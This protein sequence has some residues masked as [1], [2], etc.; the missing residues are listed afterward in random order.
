MFLL[1]LLYATLCIGFNVYFMVTAG[2]SPK[3][4]ITTVLIM[5]V[6]LIKDLKSKIIIDGEM[7]Y[8]EKLFKKRSFPIHDIAQVIKGRKTAY[9][10]YTIDYYVIDENFKE[11]FVFPESLPQKKEVEH[12]SKT[13]NRINPKARVNLFKT[14]FR[15]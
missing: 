1:Y 9:Q 5:S 10:S 2:L 7:M 4:L 6:M 8:Y 14:E 11:V 12:F 3:L 13:I 15:L